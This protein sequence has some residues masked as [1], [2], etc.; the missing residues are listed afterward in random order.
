MLGPMY[1]I[2]RFP[3]REK[4][5]KQK[6]TSALW[7]FQLVFATLEVFYLSITLSGSKEK[8]RTEMAVPEMCVISS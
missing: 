5:V 8:Q 1:F 6:T 7:I 2:V 4:L 3:P